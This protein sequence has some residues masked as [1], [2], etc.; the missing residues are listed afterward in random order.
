MTPIEFVEWAQGYYG[1]YPAGQLKD[2]Y[3]WLRVKS[4]PYLDALKEETKKTFPSQYGRPPDVYVFEK[5][6]K[7]MKV[8]YPKYKAIEY[9][10][11]DERIAVELRIEARRRG[12]DTDKKDW[13]V[14]LLFARIKEQR[15]EKPD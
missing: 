11:E 14:E 6:N 5:C 15:G 2:I 9:S 13:L 1:Q 3:V 7:T 10:E 8:E 12:I 4:E